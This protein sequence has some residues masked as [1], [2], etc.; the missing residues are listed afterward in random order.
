MN[1]RIDVLDAIAD[2]HATQAQIGS[3]LGLGRSAVSDHVQALLAVTLIAVS[4]PVRRRGRPPA[5]YRLTP[6]GRR[7]L[8][9]HRDGPLAVELRRKLRALDR[10]VAALEQRAG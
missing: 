8:A 9:A 7:E 5:V 1:T 6:K 10:R 3:W 2:G 4:C